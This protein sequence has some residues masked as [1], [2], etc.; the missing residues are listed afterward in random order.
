GVKSDIAV[1]VFGENL[2]TLNSVGRRISGILNEVE[3]TANFYLE[4][5]SGQ[6]YYNIEIDREAVATYGL[7]VN[8]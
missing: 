1:K 5:S 3:G 2:D 8:Q 7:N 4:Q 6:P